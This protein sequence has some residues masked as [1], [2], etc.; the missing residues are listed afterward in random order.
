MK[1]ILVA[2]GP[3]IVRQLG[4]GIRE[5]LQLRREEDEAET[6]RWEKKIDDAKNGRYD[7]ESF[8]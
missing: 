7:T 2:I 4:E 3:E 6:K 5:Y 1:E 8:K